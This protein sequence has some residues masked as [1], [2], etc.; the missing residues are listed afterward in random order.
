MANVCDC[1]EVAPC[2]MLVHYTVDKNDFV[3]YN[4][5]NGRG[6]LSEKCEHCT[7]K[8]ICKPTPHV[9]EYEKILD[10]SFAD[11]V[12]AAK[13]VGDLKISEWHAKGIVSNYERDLLLKYNNQLAI[14][15]K[16]G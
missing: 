11:F 9:E 7:W 1:K 16:R 6:V 14:V 3:S 12:Q 4:D 5:I 15:G 8:G 2:G 13:L 10:Q